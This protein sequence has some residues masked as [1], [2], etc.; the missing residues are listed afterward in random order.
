MT[1]PFVAV[2]EHSTEVGIP[3]DRAAPGLSDPPGGV[4]PLP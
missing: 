3:T 4:T 1:S 2:V